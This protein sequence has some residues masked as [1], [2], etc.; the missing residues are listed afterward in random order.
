MLGA[1]LGWLSI[2]HLVVGLAAGFLVG[3]VAAIALLVG[4][5]LVK[6]VG[7]PEARAAILDGFRRGRKAAWLPEQEWESML[8][9]P[10]AEVRRRLSLEAP[11]VYTPVRSAELRAAAA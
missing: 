7:N 10:L 1:L 9:L 8:A 3:G 4:I 5:G 11:P 2:G 6:T